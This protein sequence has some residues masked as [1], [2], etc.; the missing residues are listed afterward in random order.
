LFGDA[1]DDDLDGGDGNDR[2]S[3]GDGNDR[4]NG[5]SGNDTIMADAGN[6]HF[7]G[8]SGFDTIDFS[9][10]SA[11]VSVDLKAHTSNGAAT[12]SDTVWG[13]EA[14]KGTAFADMLY[15]DKADNVFWGL[16]GN[17]AFRGFAGADVFKGG[18]GADTY[19]YALNDV[20]AN[21][22]H[23]GTDVIRD[24]SVGTDRLDVA[25]MRIDG[26]E[27]FSL[28]TRADG[29]MVTAT[30]ANGTTFDVVLLEGRTGPMDLGSLGLLAG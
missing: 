5:G 26:V 29:T 2:L 23:L 20:Y 6:D 7:V 22:V 4:L 3:G 21:G 25:R 27:T 14:V 17:D 24:F 18:G 15:G 8:G 19:V 30:L 12:G 10:A 11:G 1:G 9:M 28:D 16:D 13:I